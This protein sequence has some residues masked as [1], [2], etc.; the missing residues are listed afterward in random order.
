MALPLILK[1]RRPVAAD[2]MRISVEH[3]RYHSQ[4][5]TEL[6]VVVRLPIHQLFHQRKYPHWQCIKD[7]QG[8]DDQTK[9]AEEPL[10][11]KDAGQQKRLS[12][13]QPQC[14]Q[15]VTRIAERYGGDHH[16]RAQAGKYMEWSFPPS[17][18]RKLA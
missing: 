12:A 4:A 14:L 15:R 10:T 8:R 5:D 9:S 17:R 3:S 18:Y 2:N 13:N 7:N 1:Q 11:G 6:R 16:G